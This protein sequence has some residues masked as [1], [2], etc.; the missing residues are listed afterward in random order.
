MRTTKKKVLCMLPRQSCRLGH[1]C[2]DFLTQVVLWFNLE[3]RYPS[4]RAHPH[5]ARRAR[6]VNYIAAGARCRGRRSRRCR[7]RRTRYGGGVVYEEW[8]HTRLAFLLVTGNFCVAK[9]YVVFVFVTYVRS[10]CRFRSVATSHGRVWHRR[11][12]NL[13]PGLR[14]YRWL[15]YHVRRTLQTQEHGKRGHSLLTR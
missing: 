3:V 14:Y 9:N 4:N 15:C 11:T 12:N 8:R 1:A 7:R 10:C 6:A 13:P 5:S 2:V